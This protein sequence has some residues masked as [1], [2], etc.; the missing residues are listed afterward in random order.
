ME[1]IKK[2]E[3]KNMYDFDKVIE[4]KGTHAIKWDMIKEN[5]YEPNTIPMW[6]ADMDF[7]TLPEITD[8]IIERAKHPVYGYTMVSDAYLEAVKNWMKTRHDFDIEKEWISTTSGV[9]GALKIAVQAFTEPNDAIIINKPVYYPFDFSIETNKRCIIENE[10]ILKDGKYSIDIEDFED[11][12]VKNNVKMYILCNPSNPIGKVWTKE[13]LK[14]VG[15]ICKK[16]GVIVVADEIHQDFIYKGHTHIPFYNVDESYKEFAVI[17]TAPSKTF[18]LAGLQTSN[19]II[20]NEKMCEKFNEVK[21]RDG[22]MQ[23]NI[24]GL[25]ACQAAYEHGAKWVDELVEY[26]SANIDYMTKF[27]EENIPQCKV[28]QPEGL[29]LVWVDFRNLGME[30]KVLEKFMLEKAKLWLDEGYIFGTGGAGFERFNVA[31]PRSILEKGLEQLAQAIK[32]LK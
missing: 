14:A 26:L 13:E 12:I 32:D 8:A 7:A 2:G 10:M 31:C 4:R 9:V 30:E 16:H 6:V 17:C 19:I 3:D 23:P 18:N 5:G 27:F 28:I 29:Y 25:V 1:L 20:A 24:F 11:K 21:D 22:M 15:D